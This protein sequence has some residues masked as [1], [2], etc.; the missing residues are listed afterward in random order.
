MPD[1]AIYTETAI[2]QEK[3]LLRINLKPRLEE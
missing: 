3:H 2:G 1:N